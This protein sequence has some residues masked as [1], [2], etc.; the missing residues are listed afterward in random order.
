MSDFR[1]SRELL[2][3]A[4]IITR[5]LPDFL[6]QWLSRRYFPQPAYQT[7]LY[8]TS[9]PYIGSA[10]PMPLSSRATLYTPKRLTFFKRIPRV[11]DKVPA[12]SR[13]SRLARRVDLRV[14]SIYLSLFAMTYIIGFFYDRH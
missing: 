11:A 2:L 3:L 7:L 4:V 6:S 1:E 13:D 14:T 9:M 5:F 10:M 12:F 8:R